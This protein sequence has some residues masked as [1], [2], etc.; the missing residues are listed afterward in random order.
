[1][2]TITNDWS[3]LLEQERQKDYFKKLE[4]FLDEEYKQQTIYPCEENLFQAFELTSYADTRVVIIG[5][6]PYHGPNQA[7]GLCFSVNKGVKIPPSLR[8]IYK[9]LAID[10]GCSI[11]SHGYLTKWAKQGVLMINAVLTVRA[12]QAG[13]HQKKGW[14]TFTDQVIA[15]LNKKD[16]PVVFLLWG[17]HAQ[18][19]ADLVTNPNHLIL[20]SVHP[21]PLSARRGFFECGHFSAT[22]AFL[23]DHYKQII[24]W[25][26]ED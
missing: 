5:Q 20:K 21:S 10:C 19:K 15:Y 18:K 6:D 22:N 26:I 25:Q 4:L 7:H 8:N 2:H 9:A 23:K 12:G 11:P 16:Q 24:D 1:M 14:E 13:S 3:L 17:N